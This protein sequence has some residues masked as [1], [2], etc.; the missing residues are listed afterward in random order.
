M[1]N[2]LIRQLGWVLPS[3]SGCVSAF[4]PTGHTW[5]VSW[6]FPRKH[7]SWVPHYP[8]QPS[9]F[10]PLWIVQ[11]VSNGCPPLLLWV[12]CFLFFGSLFLSWLVQHTCLRHTMNGWIFLFAMFIF[13]R[14][15]GWKKTSAPLVTTCP[16]ILLSLLWVGHTHSFTIIR[17]GFFFEQGFWYSVLKPGFVSTTWGQI[18]VWPTTLG[19]S[20][21]NR[22]QQSVT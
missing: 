12:F 18:H 4:L 19:S 11:A 13:V 6:P 2:G 15:R 3:V 22:V 20:P 5:S 1:Y 16:Y 7:S 14:T 10:T 17:G 9:L 21:E 8:V